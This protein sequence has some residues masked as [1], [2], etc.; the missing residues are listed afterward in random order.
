MGL[1]TLLP[2]GIPLQMAALNSLRTKTNWNHNKS[3]IH[4]KHI[5]ALCG[6]NVVLL[7]G[8]PGGTYSN[9]LSYKVD[10]VSDNTTATVSQ[11]NANSRPQ[12][13]N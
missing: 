1:L 2:R 7:N 10:T 3:Q 6:Q 11:M 4:T 8:K 5:N 9:R 12:G 13:G